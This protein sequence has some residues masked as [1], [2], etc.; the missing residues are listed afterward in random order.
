MKFNL[1]STLHFEEPPVK[2]LS[3]ARC[4]RRNTCDGYAKPYFGHRNNFFCCMFDEDRE[5]PHEEK[6]ESGREQGKGDGKSDNR[7]KAHKNK[8]TKQAVNEDVSDVLEDLDA[9]IPG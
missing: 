4:K 8:Q 9:P 3:C 5:V 7:S 2:R 1:G 6:E